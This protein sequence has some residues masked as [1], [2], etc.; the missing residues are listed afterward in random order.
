M[1]NSM[2][3]NKFIFFYFIFMI[4]FKYFYNIN[5][6]LDMVPVSLYSYYN[7]LPSYLYTYK[8]YDCTTNCI[9]IEYEI[10]FN[11]SQAN[12]N[13][14]NNFVNQEMYY[15]GPIW[16]NNLNIRIDYS[17]PYGIE[18]VFNPMPYNIIN[19]VNWQKLFDLLREEKAVIRTNNGI[20]LHIS[21]DRIGNLTKIGEIIYSCPKEMQS[22]MG[23]FNE[24]YANFTSLDEF[25]NSKYKLFIYDRENVIHF[26]D[27]YPTLEIRGFKTTLD[28]EK[29]KKYIKF[30]DKLALY[31]NNKINN[32]EMLKFIKSDGFINKKDGIQEKY[33]IITMSFFISLF[34]TFL[35]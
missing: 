11:K 28:I 31:S 27:I 20:H 30:M 7:S 18:M 8:E 33:D 15:N 12:L 10:A 13:K 22:F 29:F 24:Y 1:L 19:K 21:R 4:F 14:W 17:V 6:N 9:G 32:E 34:M 16:K 3:C 2:N 35:F 5:Y 23:R 26:H 25:I